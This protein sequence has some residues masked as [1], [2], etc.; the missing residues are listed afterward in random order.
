MH[1]YI[2][3]KDNW[4]P[5]IY[6]KTRFA[7]EYG[8]QSFP[9]FEVFSAVT[10]DFDWSYFSDLMHHRQRH[11]NGNLEL[12]WQIHTKMLLPLDDLDTE[13]GF[14]EFLYLAQASALVLL[15]KEERLRQDTRFLPEQR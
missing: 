8:F 11:P 9:S 10:E 13:E 15:L 3:D 1:I 5:S 2:Y 12:P 4:D 7:S 14:K 6:P